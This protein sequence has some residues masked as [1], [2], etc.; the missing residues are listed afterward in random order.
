MKHIRNLIVVAIIFGTSL[1]LEAQTNVVRIEPEAK[2]PKEYVTYF[3]PRTELWVSVGVK[4]RIEQPGRFANYAKRLLSIDQVITQKRVTYSLDA[5]SLSEKMIPDSSKHYAV[6]INEKSVAYR[7]QR[8]TDGIIRSINHPMK[9][10]RADYAGFNLLREAEEATLE[11][12][13]SWLSEEALN[14]STE[15]KMAELTAKQIMDIRASRFDILTGDS[16]QEYDGE[17]MRLILAKLDEAEKH[18]LEFFV[19]KSVETN[20]MRSV[21]VPLFASVEKS[22]LFRFSEFAGIVDK[23]DYSGEPVFFSVSATYVKPASAAK[24]SKKQGAYYNVAGHATIQVFDINRVW[25]ERSVVV[26][27]FGYTKSL[28]AKMFNRPNTHVIFN[29]F[30]DLEVLK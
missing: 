11:F 9:A 4:K 27:Q 12:D 25:V 15:L 24:K 13:Y 22:I 30:G 17:A 8:D 10:E 14:A 26:P 23:N 6:E 19:G 1:S 20:E 3:L 21:Q 5:V 16:E 18:L 2:L 28:P 29:Q 7:L